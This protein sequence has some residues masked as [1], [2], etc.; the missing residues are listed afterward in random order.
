V[1]IFFGM[2]MAGLQATNQKL[3]M[4]K[5]LKKLT[6]V[7][8]VI[9]AIVALSNSRSYADNAEQNTTNA[10]I[11]VDTEMLDQVQDMLK[12]DEIIDPCEKRIKIFNSERQLIY[13]CRGDDDQ[14]LVMLLRRSDLMFQ[15]D[16][17]SYYLL[18]D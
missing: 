5:R 8:G 6:L 13:E 18:G 12:V 14:R 16:S 15:T 11:Q 7:F 9:I 3:K 10:I 17:S 4:E 1:F 2:A